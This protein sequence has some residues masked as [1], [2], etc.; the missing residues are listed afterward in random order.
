MGCLAF[1][2]HDEPLPTL[3][4]PLS[5]SGLSWHVCAELVQ[6]LV[7]QTF[8]HFTILAFPAQ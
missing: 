7:N 4:Q 5:E 2:L 6:L 1:S 8:R 3:V